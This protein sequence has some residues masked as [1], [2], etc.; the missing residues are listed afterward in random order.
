VWYEGEEKIRSILYVTWLYMYNTFAR[1]KLASREH[2][3]LEISTLVPSYTC[4]STERL[5]MFFNIHENPSEPVFFYFFFHPICYTPSPA[6]L[7]QR[8]TN[9][10]RTHIYGIYCYHYYR[11]IYILNARMTT[12]RVR[13]FIRICIHR[14]VF[15]IIIIII[16]P[17]IFQKRLNRLNRR[18]T[19]SYNFGFF[20]RKSDNWNA[21]KQKKKTTITVYVCIQTPREKLRAK[22]SY[23]YI[24]PLILLENTYST[25]KMFVDV[26]IQFCI[27]IH[28]YT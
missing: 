11:I 9:A 4:I 27:Y 6:A 18:K 7:F 25:F 22:L 26:T 8:Y 21:K 15:Y 1:I 17:F 16:Y 3:D 24:H 12:N 20:P 23:S 2:L 5:F 28:T 13:A 14:R 10:Y 19:V